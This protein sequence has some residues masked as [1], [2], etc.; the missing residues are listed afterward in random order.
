MLKNNHIKKHTYKSQNTWNSFFAYALFQILKKHTY[1]SQNTWQFFCL[2]P[3]SNTKK[4]I[5]INL[6]SFFA[7]F[8]FQILKKAYLQISKYLAQFFCLFLFSNIKKSILLQVLKN[9]TQFL[10]IPFLKY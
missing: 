2:S 10:I 1:Q 7:Y 6:G 5:L 9:L 4:S 8:L 3:F